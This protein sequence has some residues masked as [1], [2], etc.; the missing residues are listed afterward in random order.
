MLCNGRHIEKVGYRHIEK[1]DERN[2]YLWER[3]TESPVLAE[4]R[5]AGTLGNASVSWASN[6]Q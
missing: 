3:S 6:L 2:Q 1:S 5:A 4:S